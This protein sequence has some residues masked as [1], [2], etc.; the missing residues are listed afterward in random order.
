VTDIG[1]GPLPVV[2]HG[3]DK[4]GDTPRSIALVGDLLVVYALELAG[5]FLDG[6]FDVF[7]GHVLVPGLGYGAS[8]PGVCRRV[9]P[10]EP[11]RHDDLLDD[12]REGL[13]ALGVLRPFLVLDGAPFRMA[14]HG[15]SRL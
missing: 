4:E 6:P 3:L 8:E 12:L 7:L 14:G 15:S 11:G 10:T 5:T 1:D 13:P 9:T 2:R